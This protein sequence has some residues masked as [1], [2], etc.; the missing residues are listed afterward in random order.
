[1]APVDPIA[2]GIPDYH[3]VIKEPMDISTLAENLG[4][5]KYSRIPP[6]PVDQGNANEDEDDGT[7]HPVYRMAY[8]PFYEAVMLIF[9]KYVS[10]FGDV[11]EL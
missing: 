10:Q 9:D 3:T 8:G 7:N 2:L 4:D 1:M 6:K 5:G 11:I